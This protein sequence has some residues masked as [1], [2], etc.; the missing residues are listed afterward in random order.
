MAPVRASDGVPLVVKFDPTR[1]RHD[2]DTVLD[3]ILFE[4]SLLFGLCVA[5]ALVVHRL[6]MPPI[7]GF[8]LAGVVAGP[9]GTGLIHHQELVEHLAEVGVVVLLFTVGMELAV[10]NISRMRR[11]IVVGGGIQVGLTIAVG[12]VVAVAAGLSFGTAIF[13]GFLLSLSSTAAITKILSDRGQISTPAGRHAVGIC[14]A[15]DLAVVPMILLI[16]VLG[17]GATTVWGATVGVVKASG[18]L[19]LAAGLAW[20]IVPRLLDLVARTRSREL[21]VLSVIA[22]CLSLS[23]VTAELGLS[24]A[25]GAFLAGVILGSSEFHHQAVSEV[26]PFRDT[27]ASLFFLSIGMMFD[28]SV[29]LEAPVL[30]TVSVL[31]VIAGKA[32]IARIA[33]RVLHLPQA[34]GWRV[35]LS[36]AQIGEFGFVLTQVAAGTE[37]L[38]DRLERVFLFVAVVSIAVTP[39]LFALGRFLEQRDE[40]LGRRGRDA[41]EGVSDHVVI[42]G[43]GPVG[44]A[45]ADALEA[46]EIPYRV[47]EMN[48]V[49]VKDERAGGRPIILGDASRPVVMHAL[50][51]ER[52]RLLVIAINDTE[53]T[54]R[55]VSLARRM[56][57]H[58]H[59]IARATYLGEVTKLEALEVDEVV[60]QELETSV[61]IVV[62]S[63]RHLLVPD[64]QVEARVGEV[65]SRARASIGTPPP[66]ADE[67]S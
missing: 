45:L 13:M 56:A 24:L 11:A 6:R 36:V 20:L 23:V 44:R 26:E 55:V 62:R 34:T 16:P 41:S 10:G 39:V 38:D 33:M 27:L 54:Q 31:T 28:V 52:A 53:A 64:D 43:F 59:I 60:P 4:L 57:P 17:G 3:P 46:G 5:V 30:I 58:V 61:E 50:G 18:L 12:A 32:V 66:K 21:F 19:A 29:L 22:I 63:L 9:H 8:L 48:S 42:V 2:Q 67:E 7:V 25:L 51:I 40:T 14:V 15:Q 37:L 47:V 65:R 1:R 35:G 49:T